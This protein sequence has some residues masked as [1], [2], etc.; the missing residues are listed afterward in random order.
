MHNVTSAILRTHSWQTTVH[1][2]PGFVRP[3]NEHNAYFNVK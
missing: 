1:I 2:R 3:D